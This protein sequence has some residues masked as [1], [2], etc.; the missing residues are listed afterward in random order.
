MMTSSNDI[1]ELAKRYAED[2]VVMVRDFLGADQ[3][4][5]L[6][7]SLDYARANPGPMSTD[8]SSNDEGEFFFDFLTFR[9]NPHIKKLVNDQDLLAKLAQIVGTREIRMF[10]DTILIKTGDAPPSP[11]HQD[12]PHYLVD[13]EHNFSVWMSTEVVPENESLAFIPKSHRCGQIFR[14]RSFRD[15]EEITDNG[16]FLPLSDENFGEL[17]N[18]GIRV[19][20][21][22]PGDVVVFDNRM[23]HSALR[24]R[25]PANRRAVS[26]R[27]VGD[28]ARLTSKFVSPHPPLHHMGMKLVDGAAPPDQ[29]FPIVYPP[30]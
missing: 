24:G 25:E 3:L 28:G 5:T 26:L 21:M 8:F 12:R 13:G 4:K 2:G 30:K 23:L 17:S 14:P 6:Q 22:R 19:Y 7:E 16:E 9:R 1:A 27:F 29:W 15:G 11:W 20:S 10:H 18:E